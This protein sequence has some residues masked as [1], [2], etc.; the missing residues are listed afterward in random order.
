MFR[1]ARA[2][3]VLVLVVVATPSHALFHFSNIDEVMSGAGGDPGAQYVE[4]HMQTASQNFVARTRLTYFGCDAGHTASV[5]LLVGGNVPSGASGARWIMGS[6]T[7]I[8]GITPEFTFPGGLVNG[9]G[10]VCWGAPVDLNTFQAPADPNSWSATDPEN[11]I[12]C[13]AYGGY[14]GPTKTGGT[15]STAGPAGDGTQSLTRSGST[16][17]LACPTPTNNAGATGSFGTCG[18]TTTTTTTTPGATTTTTLTPSTNPPFGGDDTGFVPP[19]KSALLKCESRVAKGVGK[20]IA[21]FAKCH[22]GRAGGKTTTESGEDGCEQAAIGTFTGKTKTAGCG[23][24]THLSSIATAVEGFVDA[25][26]AKIYCAAGT[27]F[28]GDDTGNVPADAPKGAV[29]KC[30]NRIGKGAAKL[31]AAILKCHVRRAGGK[32]TTD[33]AEDACEQ[34]AI[35]KFTSKTKITG[36]DPCTNLGDVATSLERRL[37]ESNGLVYCQ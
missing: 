9:C 36:C 31:A 14:D 30:E 21:G 3:A 11:Y 7:P 13:W 22:A 15:E 20:L 6:T 28:G 19:A 37:D 18:G 26:N 12:D 29:T 34:A 1:I 10:M 32:T 25:D 27:P 33:A 4:I 17:G 2:L 5:L 24:C 23:A 35:G 16:I 8:G